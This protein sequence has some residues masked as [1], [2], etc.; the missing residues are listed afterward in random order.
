MKLT[1]ERHPDGTWRIRD[2]QT[3]KM[4]ELKFVTIDQ[5]VLYIIDKNPSYFDYRQILPVSRQIKTGSVLTI[6][7]KRG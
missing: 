5:A 4:S 2:K 1:I 7:L 3:G 6:G